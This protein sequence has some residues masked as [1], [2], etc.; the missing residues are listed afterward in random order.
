M[1]ARA[2]KERTPVRVVKGQSIFVRFYWR[3]LDRMRLLRERHLASNIDIP[4]KV[5]RGIER[6]VHR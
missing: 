5:L 3:K 4:H 2:D 1:C 6:R